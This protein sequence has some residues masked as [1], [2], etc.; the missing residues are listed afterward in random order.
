MQPAAWDKE[1][2]ARTHR[3]SVHQIGCGSIRDRPSQARAIDARAQPKKD[4]GARFRAGVA[5]TPAQ[6]AAVDWQKVIDDA[7]A[8]I[9]GN[10][11]P[12]TGSATSSATL[13]KAKTVYHAIENR[14]G[15]LR[16]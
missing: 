1:H 15:P 7:E 8:G 3:D 6:R 11:Q 10:I 2:I 13:R 14:I 16:P 9:T 4:L 5:R 12:L